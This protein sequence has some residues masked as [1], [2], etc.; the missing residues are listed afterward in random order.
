MVFS[1]FTGSPGGAGF[2]DGTGSGARIGNPVGLALDGSGNLYVSDSGNGVIRKVTPAGAVTTFAGSGTIGAGDGIGGFASFSGPYGMAFDAAGNLLVADAGNSRIRKITPA[3]AVTTLAGSGSIGRGD[4]TGWAASFDFPLGLVVDAS[5]AAYVAD[6]YSNVIRRVSPAGVVTTLAG[7]GAQGY[8]DGPGAAAA[9]YLPSGMAIDSGGNLFV[10]DWGNNR[11]RKVTPAGVVSTFAGSG[12]Y[13]RTNGTGTGATFG[14]PQGLAFDSAGNLFV[15]DSGNNLLRK[16]TPAG[17]VSTIAGTGE[18][19]STDGP[20]ASASFNFPMSLAVDGSGNVLVADSWNALIRKVSLAGTVT[21]LVG[22]GGAGFADGTRDSARFLYPEGATVDGAGNVYVADSGNH[23]IRKISPAGTVSVLAGSGSPGAANGTGAAAQFNQPSGVAVDAAGNVYVADN[24]NQA[25]R[26]ISAAGAVTLLAGGSYGD[27]DGT[28][29]AAKFRYPDSVA[30]DSAG[31]VYVSDN[32]NHKIKKVTAA[33]VVTTLAGS[34]VGGNADGTGSAASFN[35]PHGVAV[36]ASG[37]VYVADSSN[38][39]IRKVTPGG[40]VSTLAGSGFYGTSD[41]VGKSASFSY[42]FAVALDRSGNL[43]VAD[44]DSRRIRQVTMG[45]VV[46][47]VAGSGQAGNAD[48]SGVFASFQDPF[49]IAVGPDGKVY[50]VDYA[51]SCVRVGQPGLSDTA[52]VDALTGPVGQARHFDVTSAAGTGWEWKQVRI[53][54]GSIASLS[55]TAGKN[56]TFTPDVPD[57]Y[58]FLMGASN[59]ATAAITSVSLSATPVGAACAPD[60]S[61]LCLLGGRFKVTADYAD[62]SGGHGKGKAVSLT[63]DTGYFWFF[64]AANVEAIA[65]MVSFCGSGSSNVAIY[66]GGLTDLDVT[67]HVTDTRTGATKDYHNPLGTAFGLI[68]DGPFPCPAAATGSLDGEVAIAA[69][70]G[71]SGSASSAAFALPA[72][73]ASGAVSDT[74]APVPGPSLAGTCT[75]DGT[76]LCLLSYRFQVRATYQDYGGTT[77]TARAVSLTGDTGQFWFFDARNVETVVKMVPFC[78][79]GSGNVA[80]YAGGTTDLKV[81]LEVKDVVTGLTKTYTNPLGTPFQLIRDGPFS[82]P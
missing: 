82:C 64:N 51:G 28:G 35:Y 44:A 13:G 5:G 7:T 19:G 56:P 10:C 62:Y 21:T 50:V 41:G 58:V 67:L 23:R 4:G 1:R 79:T 39:R 76:T 80:V 27:A 40:G 65:K 52:A 43:L 14:Y 6:T 12:A 48:G 3:R 33:G 71:L 59:G 38:Q 68:R 16:I 45:G 66:A 31:N 70:E 60:S 34:G 63:P 29:A 42:P 32:G 72:P 53:P 25:I 46:T 2:V 69:G 9:F 11:I 8:A 18:V 74:P 54:S 17:V 77:G 61:T 75:V 30:V 22:T 49:G 37:N 15:A 26:K 36:D 55:A 20:A 47:T 81:M 78:G 57:G 73:A 24:N